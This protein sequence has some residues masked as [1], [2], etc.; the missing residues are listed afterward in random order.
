MDG[1]PEQFYNNS[2]NVHLKCGI[3][4]THPENLLRPSVKKPKM[5]TTLHFDVAPSVN[6]AFLR[7]GHDF[8]VAPSV[9]WPFLRT[10]VAF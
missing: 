2:T 10:G 5:R 6:K 3:A 1:E 4:N 9:I 7:T 8:C